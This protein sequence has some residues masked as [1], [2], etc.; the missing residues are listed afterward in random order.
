MSADIRR[1]NG[2]TCSVD[3]NG[4]AS[5]KIPYVVSTEA[6]I[7]SFAP[8][9]RPMNLPIVGREATE[10]NGDWILTLNFEGLP[11]SSKETEIE[12]VYELDGSTS[13][14]PI[15]THPD[16]ELI[17]KKYRWDREEREFSQKVNVDGKLVR[18]PLAGA[19]AYLNVGAVWRRTF[20][21]RDFPEG[22]LRALGCI[23]EPQGKRKP[24]RMPD[25][26]NWLKRSVK[27]TWRGNV[28][29]ISEEWLGSGRGGWN[30]DLYRSK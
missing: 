25:G 18:N 8:P 11:D 13:E 1:L 2:A 27:A 19:S 17:A 14:D 9:R 3:K 21:A 16:F 22:L 10:D 4:V 12:E 20:G 15:E 23:D 26:R 7:I 5:F 6:E 30:R 28:W 24:P 29:T